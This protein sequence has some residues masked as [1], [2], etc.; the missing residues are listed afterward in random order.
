M[1]ENSNGEGKFRVAVMIHN[2]N[3][4]IPRKD[5]GKFRKQ[6][7]EGENKQNVVH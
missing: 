1:S 4:C 7:K 2:S 5:L 3:A 6:E